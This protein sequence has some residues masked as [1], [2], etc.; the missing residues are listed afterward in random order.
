MRLQSRLIAIEEI[1]VVVRDGKLLLQD[2]EGRTVPNK[3][4]VQMWLNQGVIRM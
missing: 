2:F 3:N 1:K 4:K